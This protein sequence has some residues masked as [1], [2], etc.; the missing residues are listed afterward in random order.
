MLQ[1]KQCV[2]ELFL[3]KLPLSGNSLLVHFLRRLNQKYHY[4]RGSVRNG[5]NRIQRGDGSGL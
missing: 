4:L 5:L 2:P 3:H 1:K